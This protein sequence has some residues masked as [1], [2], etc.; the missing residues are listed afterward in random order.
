MIFCHWCFH[1]RIGAETLAVAQSTYAVLWFKG[2]ELSMVFGLQ[3][4]FARVGST[5]N[6]LVME[7]LYSYV[8]KT[9]GYFGG[10]CIGIILFITAVTCVGSMICAI[11]LGLMDG[12]A[13]T[14]LSR[15]DGQKTKLVKLTDIKNFRIVF[16]LVAWICI[17]YYAAIIPFIALGK[18][19]T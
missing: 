12:H 5:A 17:T 3:Q 10:Q 14:V 6:F 4:S 19:V 15:S 1:Y 2:K 11:V 9:L 7:N 16:W 8:S 13:E 18:W